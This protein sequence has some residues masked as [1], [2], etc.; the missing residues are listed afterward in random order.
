MARRRIGS[1]SVRRSPV[2]WGIRILLAAAAAWFGYGAIS[3][4]LANAVRNSSPERAHRLAP[5]DGRIA[6][7]LSSHL[8]GT[9]ATPQDRAQADK[10]AHA[11][12]RR[13]P[14]A[15]SA[16]STLGMNLQ[17]R[18][19]TPAARRVLAYAQKLTRRDLRTQIWSIEDAVARN[20]IP[21]ALNQYDIT[22]RT[23][24]GAPDL[25]FPVLTGAIVEPSIREALVRKMAVDAPWGRD[26][27]IYAAAASPD[28]QAVL[29]LLNTMRHADI[30]VPEV[31]SQRLVDALLAREDVERAW[32]YYATIRP[33]AMRAASRD[34]RFTV[35][36]A[37]P[38]VFDWRLVDDAALTVAMEPSDQGGRFDFAS[39]P[40]A[41]GAALRQ[42]QALPP[43]DYLIQGAASVEQTDAPL[44][45]WLLACANGRELG[46]VEMTSRAGRF[47]GTVHVPQDCPV[48]SLTLMVRPSDRMTSVVGQVTEAR[49]SASPG[50]S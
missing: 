47:A 21:G 26:F 46:R 32:R 43:G 12:L 14:L 17:L 29:E 5:G 34:P 7:A 30:A 45:Y 13:A 9:D 33:R 18:G 25:L 8:F 22:L 36:H 16:L 31:A 37:A 11:A 15:V 2:E 44:P 19:D 6:A 28:T 38:T 24:R 42:M 50:R 35:R 49:L 27:V 39:A 4:S 40:G 10:L 23:I 41:G 48:Q 20:D 1:G 3:H